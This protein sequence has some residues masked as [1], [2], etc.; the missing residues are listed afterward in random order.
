MIALRMAM[1]KI[2]AR[3]IHQGQKTLDDIKPQYQEYRDYV[4]EVYYQMFKKKI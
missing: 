2:Y 1:A 4:A 3:Q